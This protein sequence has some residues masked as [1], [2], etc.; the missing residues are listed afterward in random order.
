VV[1]FLGSTSEGEIVERVLVVAYEPGAASLEQAGVMQAL[2][3]SG[4][5]GANGVKVKIRFIPVQ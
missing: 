5:N 1:Q 4:Y 2:T 3:K